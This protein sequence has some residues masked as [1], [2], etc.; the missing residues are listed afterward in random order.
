MKAMILAAGL[1]TRLRPFTLNRPKALVE[2]AGIPLLE[3]AIRKAANAGFMDIIVNVHHFADQV[4]GFIQDKEWGEVSISISDERDQLLETGGGLKKAKWFFDESQPFLLMNADII[5]SID[6]GKVMDWHLKNNAIATLVVRERK[7]SRHFLIDPKGYQLAG[8]KNSGTGEIRMGISKRNNLVEMAFSGI[9]ILNP[10]IFEL[11]DR[12][13][14]FSIIDVYLDLARNRRIFAFP[15]TESD[16]LDVGTP[17]KLRI[18]S[19]TIL[20]KNPGHFL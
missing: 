14:A 1:G 20:K 17:E 15:D 12:E 3:W 6:L 2:V 8:W 13:G 10:S 16:W 4:I 5:C 9:Q 11:M 19:E 7:S 18:A